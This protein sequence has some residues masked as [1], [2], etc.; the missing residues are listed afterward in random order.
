MSDQRVAVRQN[1]EFE[2]LGCLDETPAS[3]RIRLALQ[4]IPTQQQDQG[5]NMRKRRIA[6]SSLPSGWQS[7]HASNPSCRLP[8]H[9]VP[10]ESAQVG[11][12]GIHSMYSCHNCLHDRSR[13]LLH[14]LAMIYRKF[15]N[16]SWQVPGIDRMAILALQSKAP[17]VDL[18]QHGSRRTGGCSL[19]TRFWWQLTQSIAACIPSRGKTGMLETAEAGRIHHGNPDS[20]A[21]ALDM[22]R[23][24]SGPCLLLD[25]FPLNAISAHLKIK[26]DPTSPKWQS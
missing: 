26:I 21:K 15:G 25:H 18:V 13:R 12:R 6:H 3:A 10:R 5:D 14:R 23:L 24:N 8:L 2:R 9:G 19:K 20:R 17:G 11:A 22:V 4:T 1:I 16:A 7:I